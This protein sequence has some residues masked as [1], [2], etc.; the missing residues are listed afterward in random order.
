MRKQELTALASDIRGFLVDAVS[1]KGGH[2]ASNLGAVELTLALYSVFD[3][4]KDKLIFDVGH[5]AYTHKLL[6]G[7]MEDFSTLRDF[8][9]LSGFPKMYESPYDAFGTG[10]S[11]T[12]ISAGLGMCRARELSGENYHVVSVIGDG[13]MTG[14]LAYEALNN[15][16]Q[17]KSNFIIVLNDNEMSISRNVGGMSGFLSTFRSGSGYNRLKSDVKSTLGKIPYIG[18]GLVEKIGDSKDSLKEIVMPGGMVF[19]NMG[20][21]YLG[22]VDGHDIQAMKQIFRR[23]KKLDRCVIIHVRT[24]KGK[25]YEP[26]EKRPVYFHGVGPFDKETGK[27]LKKAAADYSKVFGHF[28]T[29]YAEKDPKVVAISAAMTENVGLAG[30]RKKFPDRFFDVGIAEQHAVTFAAGLAAGGMHPVAAI[31]STFL[32]RAYDEIV[33]DVC[34]QDLPVVFAIDRAGIVG[35]D[36]ETHQG[37]FDL[38]Y[39][40]SIPNLT[41]MTPSD[42]GELMEMLELSLKLQ[43]PAAVR[44]P[45]GTAK[46]KREDAKPVAYGKAEVLSDGKDAALLAFGA[47]VDECQ[48]AEKILKESG[49]SVT[50]VNMR[51]AKPLDEELVKEMLASYPL[52][53]TAEDGM[54]SGGAGERI[55][56]IAAG[57]K[58]AAQV[59]SVG[60]PDTFVP[61][62]EV[63][64]LYRLY[65]MDAE[66]IAKTVKEALEAA[67]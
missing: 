8:G 38:A 3:P 22:P 23:A 32:Q 24:Q 51:F 53:V 54:L 20:I 36:G 6:S 34:L 57:L 16:S 64:E 56:A 9:G 60:V 67:K 11:S 37:V 2:L 27:P 35:R 48:K 42:A 47:M 28:L 7:R 33:H 40:L 29:E 41:V 55:A 30:F 12:S 14:G 66:G 63:Q 31:Y 44:Y 5:Q 58:D 15:V 21:T 39:L 18:E 59:L 45:R 19:E 1:K 49:L 62:G 10:H 61:Q 65:G 17:L 43:K 50:V 26:A 25:G 52:V 46:K 13:S 4:P